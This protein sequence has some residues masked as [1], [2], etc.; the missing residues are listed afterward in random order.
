VFARVKEWAGYLFSAA[1]ILIFKLPVPSPKGTKFSKNVWRIIS[2]IPYGHIL[3]YGENSGY[4]I[5]RKAGTECR[6]EPWARPAAEIQSPVFNSLPQS[7]GPK[8]TGLTG[9][10][11][12]SG[13][14]KIKL[15]ELEKTEFVL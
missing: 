2:N 9:L 15:L 8:V 10:F 6:P 13:D 12:R 7:A 1:D 5:F 4:D 11:F 3:T 14:I